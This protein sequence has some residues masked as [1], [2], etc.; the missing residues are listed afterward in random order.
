MLHLWNALKGLECPNE[1]A[2]ADSRNF[3]GDIEHEM[4]TVAEINVGVAAPKKHGAVAQ[5]GSAK[6]MGGRIPLRV[7]FG[8]DDSADETRLGEVTHYK[9][10][11]KEAGQGYG[12]GREL[13]AAKT[14]DV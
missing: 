7:G 2:A 3:G 14:T 1:N 10:T 8:L 9:L 5:G 4:V 6:V 11:N 13:G 12:V